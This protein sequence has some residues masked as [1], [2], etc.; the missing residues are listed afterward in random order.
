LNKVLIIYSILVDRGDGT[1]FRL[2]A[3]QPGKRRFLSVLKISRSTVVSLGFFCMGTR[4]YFSRD[5]A[6]RA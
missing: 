5:K 3:G 2:M 4:G 1:M 6:T